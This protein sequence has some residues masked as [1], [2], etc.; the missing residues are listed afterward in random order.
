MQRWRRHRFAIATEMVEVP[1]PGRTLI[2]VSR[3]G[4]LAFPSVVLSAVLACFVDPSH[5]VQLALLTFGLTMLLWPSTGL[6]SRGLDSG[7]RDTA[8]LAVAVAMLVLGVRDDLV[9]LLVDGRVRVSNVYHY[10]LG[11]KYSPEL[12]YT[13]LYAATLAA[14]R[15]SQGYWNGAIDEVRDLS[16][17]AIVPREDVEARY[18]PEVM[19]SPERWQSFKGDVEALSQHRRTERWRSIFRDRGYNGTPL[20]TSLGRA[21]GSL[22]PATSPFLPLLAVLDLVLLG[23]TAALLASTFGRTRSILVLLLFV[24]S[25]TNVARLTGGFLQ[26]DWLCAIVCS[27]CFYRRRW[28]GLAGA[29]MA[30]A[31]MTRIFP[32]LFVVVACIPAIRQTIQRRRIP[33]RF[34]R[35]MSS[36]AVFCVLGLAVSMANGRG[37]GAWLEFVEAINLHRD[38]HV[39]GERRIGLEHAFTGDFRHFPAEVSTLERSQSLQERQPLVNVTKALLLVLLLAASTWR[40]TW[41]AQILGLLAIFALLVLSRYYYGVL[42]LTP[43]MSVGGGLRRHLLAGGQVAAFLLYAL[44]VNGGADWHSAYTLL[45]VLLAIYFASVMG[46]LAFRQLLSRNIAAVASDTQ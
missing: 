38:Q 46:T 43:L 45:N 17:Y 36:F 12:G 15:E 42:A 28:P 2:E 13:D 1:T 33:R 4:K 30:F 44:A 8:L 27:F 24:A 41:D 23:L 31:A 25:P 21:F 14:D 37:A 40:R 5:S 20:W 9:H 11:A 10:Y 32:L 3:R 29:L 18:R 34:A 22:V 39:L 26:T 16:S 7:L 35:Y 19:F 6:R